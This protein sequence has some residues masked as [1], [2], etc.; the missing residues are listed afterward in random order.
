MKLAPVDRV[1]VGFAAFVVVLFGTHA[2]M[3]L[4]TLGHLPLG[5]PTRLFLACMVPLLALWTAAQL[6]RRELLLGPFGA[7]GANRLPLTALAAADTRQPR[8][9]ARCCRG[10]SGPMALPRSSSCP[11][12]WSSLRW[13][14]CWAAAG[15]WVPRWRPILAATLLVAVT[16]IIID[17]FQPAFFASLVPPGVRWAT[18]PERAAGVMGDANTAAFIVT[19]LTALLLRYDRL[20]GADLAVLALAGLAVLAT[21]SRGGLLL[22]VM[23]AGAYLLATRTALRGPGLALT[24][25]GALGTLALL[26][27]V[28]LPAISTLPGF[29]DWESQRRLEMLTFERS[30]V[31]ED[32][33]RLSLVASYLA[34]IEQRPLVGHGTGFMRS[35]GIGTHNIY[36]RYWLDN[37][38]AGAA[39]L[40]GISRW[41]RIPVLAATVLG[42]SRL[43]RHRRRA[44]PV[45]P[46]TARKP[47][48]PASARHRPC[49]L[50]ADR[51]GG[52]EQISRSRFPP[53]APGT[54]PDERE[55]EDGERHL[56]GLG[57]DERQDTRRER[58]LRAEQHGEPASAQREDG[59]CPQSERCQGREPGAA[60]AAI[61][62]PADNHRGNEEAH[63]VAGG[64]TGEIGQAATAGEDRQ[65]D[66]TLGKIRGQ[67]DT[68]EP[69]TVGS[70]DPEH[71]ES[72]H[73]HR[74]GPERHL[75]LR[76]SDQEQTAEND[77][78]ASR[79]EAVGGLRP[80]AGDEALLHDQAI[81]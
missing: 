27:M 22:M 50:S 3:L 25:A 2:D 49:R 35:Q 65:P 74:H 41:C 37:G 10:R 76:R 58:D 79:R 44:R 45:Q 13:R 56:G 20:R 1:I 31:P 26:V 69:G 43:R 63:Q 59:K 73:G 66:G 48:L 23:L 67:R 32:E 14:S 51:A 53:S 72:L 80:K 34:T 15:Q 9:R 5:Q 24:V 57:D 68:G 30:M 7:L 18:A 64:R 42:R 81:R 46:H 29:S 28:I 19:T 40:S 33:S 6:R 70:T 78:Q 16:S 38:L 62:E 11:T 47:W 39:R 75:H 60:I 4:A 52:A 55:D 54:L 12:R 36:L 61:G 71:D 8:S 21:Q 17:V 77:E